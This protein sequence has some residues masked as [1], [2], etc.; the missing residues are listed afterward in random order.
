MTKRTMQAVETAAERAAST[1]GEDAA[2]RAA[3]EE[4]TVIVKA[5][6]ERLDVAKE[7][8]KDAARMVKEAREELDNALDEL[9]RI[10]GGEY[11]PPLPFEGGKEQAE[12]KGD[13]ST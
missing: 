7:A 10:A 6:K 8:R 2:F 3:L 9:L 11:E 5:K 4:Q 13:G 12:E 1:A